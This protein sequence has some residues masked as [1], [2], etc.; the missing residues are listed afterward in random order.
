M[1]GGGNGQPAQNAAAGK[2]VVR[3]RKSKKHK[4]EVVKK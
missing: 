4:K 1:K 3:G 2:D